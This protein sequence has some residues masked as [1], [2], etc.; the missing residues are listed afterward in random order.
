M[1]LYMIYDAFN[2][3][4][5]IWDGIGEQFNGKVGIG[6]GFDSTALPQ[7]AVCG[8]IVNLNIYCGINDT[9]IPTEKAYQ[10]NDELGDTLQ[11]KRSL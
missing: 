10:I 2:E 8:W 4:Y 6:D 11:D 7:Q 1:V 5:W 9:D 3:W